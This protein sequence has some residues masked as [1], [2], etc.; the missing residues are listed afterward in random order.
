MKED[1]GVEGGE[2][3]WVGEEEAG[4]EEGERVSVGKGVV[5]DLTAMV[6]RRGERTPARMGGDHAPRGWHP[7][8]RASSVWG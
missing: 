3:S 5:V 2:L 8:G 4:V 7:D 6:V 1:A